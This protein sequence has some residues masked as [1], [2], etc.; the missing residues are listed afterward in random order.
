V[1]G[2]K[3]DL[4]ITNVF[5]FAA[6]ANALD[7]QRRD[8]SNTKHDIAWDGLTFNGVDIY[9]DPLA[10]SALASNFLSLAPTAG[11]AGNNNLVDG[12]GGSTQTSTIV[13][14]QF[15]SA[16]ANVAQSATGS[17]LPSNATCTVGEVLYFLEAGA[18]R[19]ARPT[20][21]AG[22]SACA[23]ARCRTTCQWM[24]CSCGSERIFT[25]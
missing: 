18:S 20:R 14:P 24:R 11:K 2:G 8:V 1:T 12:A 17:N 15:T 16:G 23:E 5:G 10:P 6:V 9:A 3:P 25:T 22:T 19:F 13:T 7:A 4:G 21:R